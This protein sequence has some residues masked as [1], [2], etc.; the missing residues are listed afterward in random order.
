MSGRSY[1]SIHRTLTSP[2]FL[3]RLPSFNPR[4]LFHSPYRHISAFRP[5]AV[6]RTLPHISGRAFLS[7]ENTYPYYTDTFPFVLPANPYPLEN[8]IFT[9]TIY[10]RLVLISFHCHVC[11]FSC[12]PQMRSEK[13]YTAVYSGAGYSIRCIPVFPPSHAACCFSRTA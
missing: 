1:V 3:A 10:V 13:T 8:Y 12:P 4:I 7:C 2:F 6:F 9:S 5:P 11:L